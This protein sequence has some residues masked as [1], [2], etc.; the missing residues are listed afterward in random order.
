MTGKLKEDISYRY[1]KFFNGCTADYVVD[2]R[3]VS[4]EVG[5]N[6]GCVNKIFA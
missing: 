2:A 1:S 5:S 6:F 3:E 4:L